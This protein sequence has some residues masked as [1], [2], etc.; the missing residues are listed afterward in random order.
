[1]TPITRNE[2][3]APGVVVTALTALSESGDKEA[4]LE[5]VRIDTQER[6]AQYRELLQH[7]IK[8]PQK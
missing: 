2:K 1:L 7:Y 4:I 5:M 8:K 3:Y 6:Y